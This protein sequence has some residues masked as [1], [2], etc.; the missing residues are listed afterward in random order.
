[1]VQELFAVYH[2]KIPLF[3]EYWIVRFGDEIEDRLAKQKVQIQVGCVK[4]A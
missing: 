4:E 3:E 2:K 1:M